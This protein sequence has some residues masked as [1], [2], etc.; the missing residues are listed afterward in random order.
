MLAPDLSTDRNEL[1]FVLNGVNLRCVPEYKNLNLQGEVRKPE[2]TPE[3]LNDLFSKLDLSGVQE[4]LEDLQQKVH[5]LMIEYQHLF[6]LNDLELGK[7]L[8]VKHKIKLNNPMPFKDRYHCIPPHEFEEVRNHLQ[9]NLQDML[10]VGAIRKSVSPWA[11]PVVLVCKKD[12]SLRF[13]IDLWKLNSWTIKDVYS[14]PRIEESLDCLNG[15]IIFTSLDLKAGYWQMEMEENS[16][17]YTAFTV[18]PL[19]FYE[20]VLM[21]FGLTN[22]PATF[23]YL[24]ESCLGDYHLKYCIIYLDDIIIFSKTPEEHIDR[25]CK[26]FQKLDEAGLCLKPSKCEFFLHRLEYLGHVVSSKGIETNP[27]KIAAILNWP[28]PQNI[29]QVRSFLGFCNYY[30]KF[31]GGYAQVARPLYQLLTGENAKKKTNEI[32]WTEQCEQAFNKL[33]EICSDTPI[34][35]YADYNK[36]F[37]VHTDT[38]EQ[39][40]GA[41]LYQD[42]DDGTTRVITYA[43]RNLSKSEKRYHSSK[44]EFLALKWSVCERFH[45]YL[46]G[47]KFQ[48]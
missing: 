20:C 4:W 12:G 17:P 30:R 25:L 14:L 18:G 8:K 46:Y 1:E 23:Q 10:K 15:A 41:V 38:S 34:L 42:Q 35:A 2:P 7:T 40:L 9:D 33:K 11:S 39:G 3:R 27:K 6:A 47:G 48:V 44:L 19:G 13:C 31:I 16:I 28:Q 32:E 24:M 45:E 36:C 21:P 22:A 43:S 26:V 37:K 5:D 29:T